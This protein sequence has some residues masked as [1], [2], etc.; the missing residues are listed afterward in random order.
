VG[1]DETTALW[2][3]IVGFVVPLAIA[4]IN[5]SS[6]QPRTRGGVAFLVCLLAATGTVY[7]GGDLDQID[8]LAVAFLIVFGTAIS[9]DHDRPHGRASHRSHREGYPGAL[10]DRASVLSVKR[11]STRIAA[12]WVRQRRQ[13]GRKPYPAHG[14]QRAACVTP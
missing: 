6:W 11:R 12:A 13:T 10:Q 5:Q 9:T 14:R 7:F 1:I 4:A 3:A 8:D 2:S